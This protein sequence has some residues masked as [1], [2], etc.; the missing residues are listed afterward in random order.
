MNECEH[1]IVLDVCCT[2]KHS[3]TMK[4]EKNTIRAS[5]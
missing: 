2:I 1:V 3:T 4:K 5:D